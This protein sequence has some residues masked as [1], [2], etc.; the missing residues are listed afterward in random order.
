MLPQLEY[1]EAIQHP[2]PN[3]SSPG[4]VLHKN[5]VVLHCTDGPTAS[6]AISWFEQSKAPNRISAHFV[7][8]RDGTVYQLVPISDVAWHASECNTRS[9]GIEHAGIPG[10]M[11]CTTE[12]YA[13]S[14]KLIA[15]CCQQIGVTCDREHVQPHSEASP[16]DGHVQC[17][18][19]AL[20]VEELVAQAA[21]LK[22]T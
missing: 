10:T 6:S 5:L 16:R 14:S 3:H 21:A 11:L 17:C 22:F 9:I 8:D 1:P 18:G 20:N 7:I 2:L 4:S 13:A 12:Q 19:G 15:W